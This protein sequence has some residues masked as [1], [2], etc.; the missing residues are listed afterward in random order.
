VALKDADSNDT[1]SVTGLV[2]TGSGDLS[3]SFGMTLPLAGFGLLVLLT[4][5]KLTQS[6]RTRRRRS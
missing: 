2:Q 3:R 5:L 1:E 6:D 4:V